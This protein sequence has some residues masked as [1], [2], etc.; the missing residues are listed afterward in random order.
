MSSRDEKPRGGRPGLF[1]LL[2]AFA[3]ILG[4][5]AWALWLARRM[6]GFRDMTV[7]GWIALGLAL[8]LGGALTGGLMWLAF[9]SA[10]KGYDDDV[11][12]GRA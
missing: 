8:L 11:G 6:E 1:V 3:V 9:Y 4:L 2:A 10:R 7:H 5:S 12:D